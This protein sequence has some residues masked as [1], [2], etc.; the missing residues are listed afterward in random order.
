[1]KL[2]SLVTSSGGC[3]HSEGEALDLLLFY[4]LHQ[5]NCYGGGIY[6]PLLAELN[7]WTGGWL[8]GILAIVGLGG[9]L[10]HLPQINFQVWME[11]SRLY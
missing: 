3:T 10:I 4:S 5:L 9:R 1:M 2:G 7:V 8:Q 11:Y 6:T